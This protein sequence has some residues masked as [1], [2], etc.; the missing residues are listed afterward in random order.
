ML[1]VEHVR[2]RGKDGTGREVLV[3]GDDDA[4]LAGVDLLPRLQTE[5]AGST[6]QP[7]GC[8]VVTGPQGVGTVLDEDHAMGLAQGDHARHIGDVPAHV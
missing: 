5:A 7:G 8:P 6:E 4:A 2:A 1:G 3:V